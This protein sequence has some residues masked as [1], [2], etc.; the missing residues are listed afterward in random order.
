MN[1][2]FCAFGGM[3]ISGDPDQ[4]EQS[5]LCLPCLHMGLCHRASYL[6]MCNILLWKENNKE[7]FQRWLLIVSLG[8]VE[9][10]CYLRLTFWHNCR[11]PKYGDVIQPLI[12]SHRPKL[13]SF[14]QIWNKNHFSTNARVVRFCCLVTERHVKLQFLERLQISG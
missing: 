6:H 14:K 12:L 3:A 9:G 4:E 5:D 2:A 13:W 10:R 1:F 8:G 7:I 11:Y